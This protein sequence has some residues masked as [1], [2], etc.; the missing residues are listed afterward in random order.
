MTV[1]SLHPIQGRKR[2]NDKRRPTRGERKK[3]ERKREKSE[4]KVE[5]K[6]RWGETRRVRDVMLERVLV[7]GCP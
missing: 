4:R 2:R 3:R 6:G 7:T 5:E 1:T